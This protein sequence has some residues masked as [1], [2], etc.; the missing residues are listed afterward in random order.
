M[1]L[2][3]QAFS[4][5]NY[6]RAIEFFQEVVAAEPT[7]PEPKI[8]LNNAIARQNGSLFNLAAVISAEDNLEI[9]QEILRGVAEAQNKFNRENGK[10][11]RLLE[12][13]IANDG[14]NPETAVRIAKQ[15]EANP[16]VL[17]VIGHSSVLTTSVAMPIYEKAQ[18]AIVPSIDPKISQELEVNFNS[19]VVAPSWQKDAS[20]RTSS[21]GATQMLIEALSVD[22]TR[23]TVFQNT[24]RIGLITYSIKI[25]T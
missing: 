10:D 13:I 6:A 21:L 9:S 11:G 24:T 7:N 22:A 16:A 23:E 1:K 3:I 20:W 18:I 5:G 17:G 2:G 14:N 25:K 4:S 12:I 15:L 8:Y 19:E